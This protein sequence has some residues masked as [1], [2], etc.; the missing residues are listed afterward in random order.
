MLTE[1]KTKHTKHLTQVDG[2]RGT[3]VKLYFFMN[4]VPAGHFV[5]AFDAETG[6]HNVGAG[7]GGG[8]R[9]RGWKWWTKQTS[10]RTRA[11][12]RRWKMCSLANAE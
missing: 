5:A 3:S 8:P 2:N 4:H 10:R 9:F 6:G 12:W 1:S 11:A 7:G